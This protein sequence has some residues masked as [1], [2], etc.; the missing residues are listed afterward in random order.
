VGEGDEKKRNPLYKRENVRGDSVATVL[1]ASSQS[2]LA[3]LFDYLII[4]VD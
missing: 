2:G 3:E 4:N 1:V